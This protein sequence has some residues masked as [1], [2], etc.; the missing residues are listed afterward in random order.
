MSRNT[1]VFRLLIKNNNTKKKQNKDDNTKETKTDVGTHIRY[2]THNTLSAVFEVVRRSRYRCGFINFY[3]LLKR[4]SNPPKMSVT[5]VPSSRYA[6]I[7]KNKSYLIKS[8]CIFFIFHQYFE[9][10]II[11]VR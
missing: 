2:C 5:C 6:H 8:R 3:Y 11:L 1:A 10:K 7:T 9:L 4:F